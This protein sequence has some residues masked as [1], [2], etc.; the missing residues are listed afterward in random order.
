[1]PTAQERSATPDPST[2]PDPSRAAR[3][4]A[5][6]P[7]GLEALPAW[8]RRAVRGWGVRRSPSSWV[9]GVLGGVA[10]R[11]RI[12]PLLARGVFVALCV[13][14]AG[15]GLLAYA[16]AWAVLP[17][18]DGRVQYG[19]LRRGEWQD[20]T[21]AIGVIGAIGAV[22]LLLGA[23]FTLIAPAVGG[24]GSL[25]G[26][27]AVAVLGWWLVT[28]W[29]GRA[30]ARVA[31]ARTPAA[32]GS[33]RTPARPAWY[34]G[35]G[36]AD[37]PAAPADPHGF[38]T[39]WL[40]PDTGAWRERVHPRE[41]RA[42][43]RLA[44]Q[45]HPAP[46]SAP[47]TVPSGRGSMPRPAKPRLGVLPQVLTYAA[48]ALAA[49]TTLAVSL[50]L[51]VGGSLTLLAVP[52]LVAALAVIAPVMLGALLSGRRPGTLGPASGILVGVTALQIAV[53]LAVS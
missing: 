16:A 3:A 8:L 45:T 37:A 27:G 38:R 52:M 9:G 6:G 42:A 19:R 18:A 48:A 53:V 26:L 44:E 23:G 10:E 49:V 51:G 25:L 32:D 47:S 34:V 1:M 20:A 24:P 30:Q 33:V 50:L 15:V 11:Y 41:H 22:N 13:V 40:N 29:D 31:P 14:S 35:R 17:D 21:V 7:D 46:T 5:S 12:D 4:G 36:S 39:D 28:R 2:T 43:A